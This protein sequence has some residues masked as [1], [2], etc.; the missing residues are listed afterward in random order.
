MSEN[1]FRA[2]VPPIEN[3]VRPL[4]SVMIPAY[5]RGDYLRETLADVLA[6]DPGPE[7]M[8][9]E[10]IDDCSPEED[11][12]AIVREVGGGRVGFYRQPYNV[13]HV[14]NFQTGLER[15]TGRLIHLLHGDDRVRPGF[16]EKMR[17]AFARHPEI[18]AA[19]CR[20]IF[21]DERGHWLYL[22]SL[23][24]STDGILEN[25]LERIAV[26][27]RIQTPSIVV[28]REVYERLGGFDRRLPGS[29][30]D[31]EMW[32]RIAA[33]YP[34]WYD[35]EPLAL[36]RV[37][38]NSITGGQLGSAADLRDARRAIAIF[39]ADLPAGSAARLTAKALENWA[40]NAIRH[41]IPERLAEND[42][43]GARAQLWEALRTSRAPS[44][45]LQL[46]ALGLRL[47]KRRSIDILRTLAG[48]NR[49]PGRIS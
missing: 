49:Q 19:F 9:I 2:R 14:K 25:W 22:S 28:R 8:Q 48:E 33:R 36:Y 21:I 39:E 42:L 43:P 34:V 7:I 1:N 6:Q 38:A 45:W 46:L 37:H 41:T 44:V 3:A 26:E 16:Y 23:E 30:E 32:V 47:G 27:Q 11:L 10:V 12:E 40:V 15:S 17:A 18:G 20:H 31:W 24:R 13:G 29:C 5:N 35:T 4:W